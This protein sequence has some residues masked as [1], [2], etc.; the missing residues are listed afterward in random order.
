[1]LLKQKK[2]LSEKYKMNTAANEIQYKNIEI[3]L[4][5]FWG[6]LRENISR[7]S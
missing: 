2:A 7:T 5:I 3:S 4:I 1:M 6:V